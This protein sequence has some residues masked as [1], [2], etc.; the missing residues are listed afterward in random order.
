MTLPCS[1]QLVFKLSDA[2]GMD[3]Y[4]YGTVFKG[5]ADM[6]IR[7]GSFTGKMSVVV[8]SD[9][10]TSLRISAFVRIKGDYWMY[11]I[12]AD[13][14]VW[15]FP[16]DGSK[17]KIRVGAEKDFGTGRI[18]DTLKALKP[19]LASNA[20][21]FNDSTGQWKDLNVTDIVGRLEG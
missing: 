10:V 20:Y 13:A 8:H 18:N 19:A 6:E 17:V 21:E 2:I 5:A 14:G 1:D 11:L 16:F 9:Q 7:I 12:S 3:L 4:Q 15:A